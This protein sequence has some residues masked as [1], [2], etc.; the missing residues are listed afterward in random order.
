MKYEKSVRRFPGFLWLIFLVV[1]TPVKKEVVVMQSFPLDDRT[2]LLTTSG[3]EVDRTRFVEGNGSVKITATES[4]VIA[5]FETGDLDLENAR[6]IYQAQLSSADLQG[7]AFLEMWCHFNGRGEYF[8]RA[9]QS[10]I[11][12]DTDWALHETPFFLKMGEN[13]DN[14]KL[15]LVITGQGTVWIDD[16]KLLKSP[17]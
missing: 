13:P 1:C 7:E 17:L 16:V 8:S 4:R 5:L 11:S 15:N 9:L 3:V 14:I 10:K 6:L 12:G 2:G